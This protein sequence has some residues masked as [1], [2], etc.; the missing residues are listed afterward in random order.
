MDSPNQYK[1]ITEEIVKSGGVVIYSTEEDMKKLSEINA[2]NR[3]MD[4]CR[5]KMQ[6]LKRLRDLHCLANIAIIFATIFVLSI[7][8]DVLYEKPLMC[9]AILLIYII[10]YVAFSLM[11]N[12]LDFI[13]NML[14]T[15]SL[16]IINVMFAFLLVFNILICGVYRYK[17]GDLGEHWGYPLFYNLR[18]ERVRN[19]KYVQEVK[20]PVHSVMIKKMLE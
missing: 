20:I 16:L 8:E 19:E 14:M 1:Y 7:K 18:V 4:E 10:V 5:T 17:K 3:Y 2:Y 12:E 9:I 6:E 15:A 11:K 13:L